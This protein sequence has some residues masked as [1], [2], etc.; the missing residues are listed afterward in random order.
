MTRP[1]S[2]R[3]ALALAGAAALAACGRTTDPATM[4]LVPMGDFRLGHNVVVAPNLTRGPFSREAGEAELI[5][6][7]QGAMAARLSRYEG[8][9][10]YHVG[11]SIEAY[12]LAAPGIPVAFSPKSIMIARVTVWDD[13]A[14]AKLN[15]EAEQII[16]LES[17]SGRTLLG[18]G[19]TQSK[20]EQLANLAFNMAA[21][22]QRWML[23]RKSVV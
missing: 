3:T 6:A 23:D 11:L 12:V 17:I 5:E 20:E 1:L 19:L 14:G 8:A 22:V 16:V 13:A 9:K 2:R 15:A 21:A 4:P 7:V 10:L 18:S